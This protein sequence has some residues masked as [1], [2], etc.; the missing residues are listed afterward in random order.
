[1]DLVY[2][3]WI[4]QEMDSVAIGFGAEG[5]LRLF[6]LPDPEPNNCLGSA[7]PRSYLDMSSVSAG[8]Y[9]LVID[10]SQEADYAVTIRCYPLPTTAP[11]DGN[12]VQHPA[13]A[14]T[15]ACCR[16]LPATP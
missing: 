9:Y 10:G 2:R 1:M 14:C 16:H 7:A 4:D 11:D 8:G 12:P 3:L 5:Y 6:F 13:R 15:L